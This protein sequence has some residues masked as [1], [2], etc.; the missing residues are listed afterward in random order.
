MIKKW[1]KIG[2]ITKATKG[3]P[4]EYLNRFPQSY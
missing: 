1:S 2:Q 4:G 3:G